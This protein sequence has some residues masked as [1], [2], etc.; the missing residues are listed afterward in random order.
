M[1]SHK[2]FLKSNYE[3][4]KGGESRE[5][6]KE[7]DHLCNWHNARKILERRTTGEGGADSN[8]EIMRFGSR[9]DHFHFAISSPQQ[10]ATVIV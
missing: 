9:S 3:G 4:G 6:E 5:R 10:Q 2:H 1:I 8:V 7:S